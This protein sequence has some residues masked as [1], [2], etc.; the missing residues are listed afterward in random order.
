[1]F[2]KKEGHA[3]RHKAITVAPQTP[4]AGELWSN[5][6]MSGTSWH[7]FWHILRGQLS[8]WVPLFHFLRD[9]KGVSDWLILVP[10]KPR[11]QETEKEKESDRSSPEPGLTTQFWRVFGK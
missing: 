3:Q 4:A 5:S 11:G 7:T 2:Q 9:F 10:R 6:G 1:M 8:R